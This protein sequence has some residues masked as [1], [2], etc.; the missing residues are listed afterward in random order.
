MYTPIELTKQQKMALLEKAID[1]GAGIQVDFHN[2][3]KAKAAA[4]VAEFSEV[5]G[6]SL[7]VKNR[8]I[9]NWYE[10][11]GYSVGVV[12]FYK[13]SEYMEEDVSFE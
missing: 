6:T 8:G 7:E 5:M 2:L 12:A 1:E 10:T 9:A 13:E 4:I 3:P 11:R